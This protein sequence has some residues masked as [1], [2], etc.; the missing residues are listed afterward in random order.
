MNANPHPNP[1]DANNWTAQAEAG[2]APP[3]LAPAQDPVNPNVNPLTYHHVLEQQH[4]TLAR[5]EPTFHE[6]EAARAM[7]M[8]PPP[9]QHQ[10]PIVTVA[11]PPQ[12]HAMVAAQHG[13]YLDRKN[14]PKM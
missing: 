9:P 5:A 13:L 6:Q 3:P 4:V 10:A 11:H 7:A 1:D 8:A 2:T 12:R 14:V